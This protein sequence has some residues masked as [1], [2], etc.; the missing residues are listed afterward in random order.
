MRTVRLERR[1][2]AVFVHVLSG[3]NQHGSPSAGQ[4]DGRRGVGRTGR[5]RAWRFCDADRRL[6]PR[7][8]RRRPIRPFDA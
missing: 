5:S 6:G 7:R 4:A 3:Q 2:D 1:F 8:P